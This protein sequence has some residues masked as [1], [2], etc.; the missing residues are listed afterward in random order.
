MPHAI[1]N[2]A[3]KPNQHVYYC[4]F[5]LFAMEFSCFDDWNNKTS[6]SLFINGPNTH[7]IESILFLGNYMR[8]YLSSPNCYVNIKFFM[9]SH[10]IPSSAVS[11]FNFEWIWSLLSSFMS[12]SKWTLFFMPPTL[13]HWEMNRRFKLFFP[14]FSP[15]MWWVSNGK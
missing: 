9:F 7:T 6:P 4:V 1:N 13:H 3:K 5:Q 2:K 11:P 12:F 10:C 15:Y 8:C 14:S